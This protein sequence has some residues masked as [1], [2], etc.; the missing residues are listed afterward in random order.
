MIWPSQLV[1]ITLYNTL[2]SGG[3]G[4]ERALTHQRLRYFSIV[5]LGIFTYQVHMRFVLPQS[6]AA[7]SRSGLQFLP[8][9]IAP[10]LTSI[11]VLCLIDN[12]STAM[13]MLGSACVY[14]EFAS[15]TS[16]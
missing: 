3:T 15:C 5:F 10:I 11:A 8:A 9:V 12:G 4:V 16:H 6:W 14:H 7:C 13:R 2:H 1:V